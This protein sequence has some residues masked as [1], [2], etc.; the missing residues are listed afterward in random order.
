MPRLG[1]ECPDQTG[2]RTLQ[3]EIGIDFRAGGLAAIG[4]A[5]REDETGEREQG[6]QGPAQRL[7]QT[8]YHGTSSSKGS[9]R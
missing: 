4:P 7:G 5:A 8:M 6:D 9:V 3:G 2:R 1:G